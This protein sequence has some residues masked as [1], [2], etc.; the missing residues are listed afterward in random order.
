MEFLSDVSGG[1]DLGRPS[2]F[3]LAAQE[4]LRDLL[5]PV[6]RYILSVSGVN[7]TLS[8]NDH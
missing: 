3:E 7:R 2:F 8:N 6:I 1:S 4:Q 5:A